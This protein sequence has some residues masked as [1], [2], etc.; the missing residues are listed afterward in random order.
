MNCLGWISGTRGTVIIE[1]VDSPIHHLLRPRT[2]L[3]QGE[4]YNLQ[5]IISVGFKVNNEC[6][7][8][9]GKWVIHGQT[10]SE[11]IY[12]RAVA[13]GFRLFGHCR[14]YGTS[15]YTYDDV[16]LGKTMEPFYKSN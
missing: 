14:E 15:A 12:T 13:V 6:A 8:Q 1:T 9:F 4:H 7:V 10:A 5:M 16:G 2:I 11:V 3:T